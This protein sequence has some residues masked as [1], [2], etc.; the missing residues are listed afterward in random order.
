MAVVNV[1]DLELWWSHPNYTP[2]ARHAVVK[3][4]APTAGSLF[5]M[6]SSR[7]DIDEMTLSDGM[8]QVFSTKEYL[9]VG[10]E[11]KRRAYVNVADLNELSINYVANL[12]QA[13]TPELFFKA[14]ADD[15]GPNNNGVKRPCNLQIVMGKSTTYA[16]S[17]DTFAAQGSRTAGG[18]QVRMDGASSGARLYI[19]DFIVI[20]GATTVYEIIGGGDGGGST[21]Q[22]E[23]DVSVFPPLTA[24]VADNA[25]ITKQTPTDTIDDA[26]IADY[27]LSG[28]GNQVEV[29]GQVMGTA[30]LQAAGTGFQNVRS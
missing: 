30:T 5:R 1:S 2:S 28:W 23:F 3:T 24:D 14:V 8:T 13:D 22:T 27:I 18:N 17:S 12:G 19:G 9:G 29:D 7:S 26:N 10:Q 21:A 6:D 25:V 20:A 15:P 4:A 11:R 16:T